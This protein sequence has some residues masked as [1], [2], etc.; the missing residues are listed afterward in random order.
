[1]G[2]SMA[3]QIRHALIIGMS[4]TAE[5]VLALAALGIPAFV[6]TPDLFPE[7]MAA[8]IQRQDLTRWVAQQGLT[9]QRA[10]A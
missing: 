2:F 4:W 1:M 5:Q 8:A 6:C 10:K 7:L 9:T 3:R